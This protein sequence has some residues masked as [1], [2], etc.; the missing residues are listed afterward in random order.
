[1]TNDDS[2]QM[3]LNKI[4]ATIGENIQRYDDRLHELK[5]LSQILFME[6]RADDDLDAWFREEGFGINEDGFWLSLPKLTA[7][8]ENRAAQDIISYSWHPDLISNKDACFRMYALRNIGPL[9]EEIWNSL[10]ETAWIYYQDITNTSLQFPYIDQITAISP[11]FDWR[12]YHTFQSVCPQNNPEGEIKWTQP[13]IDY[14]GEGLI[15]SVSIPVRIQNRFIGLWSIDLP[16]VS[17]YPEFIF[18]TLLE[19]QVNF[20]VDQDGNLVAHP[21]IETRIDSEKGSL[22]QTHFH[23]LGAGFKSLSPRELLK[24]KEGHFV[25]N[26]ETASES[27]GYYHAIPG[28]HWLLFC[29][30]PRQSMEHVIDRKIKTAFERVKSGDFS[31]RLNELS[32]VKHSK[33]IADGFNEM[34]RA[35]EN[36]AEKQKKTQKEKDLLEERI[37]HYQKM[38]AIGTLAGGIAHDFN[39][40]LFPIQGYAEM[41]LDD[42]P[43][44]DPKHEM[45]QEILQAASRAKE[46][47]EQILTF[48]RQGETKNQI[49]SLQSIVKEALK[50]LRSTIPKNIEIRQNVIS[51]CKPVFADPTNLHQVI[52]NLCTNAFHAVQEKGGAIDVALE[53]IRVTTEGQY[54]IVDLPPGNYI[55]LTVSDT[56]CGMDKT[57]LE[58]IFNPYF[59]T[60]KEGKGTGLGLSISYGII[61]TLNGEIKVYSEPNKG[62]TFH[63][64][65]PVT[66]IKEVREPGENINIA[67]GTEHILLVDDE[68]SIAQMGKTALEKYGYRVSVFTSSFEALNAFEKKP[69]SFDLLLTDMTMPDMT[70]DILVQHIKRIRDNIPVIICTGFNENISNVNYADKGADAFLMKPVAIHK[71]IGTIRKQLDK[72]RK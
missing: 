13:T 26:P 64:Y 48:S 59:T 33:I 58:Q 16:M 62:T 46:L 10:P 41:F 21:H 8:R 6:T 71:L 23:E 43:K 65:I 57:T 37:R 28:V 38:E 4:A 27:V 55:R 42:F 47:I 50:L 7:F 20:I 25:L 63:V 32:D 14:A 36:Q 44:D 60:K 9:L 66:S 2:I 51:K 70:G 19:G 69:A 72:I 52:M 30:F 56:G 53:E 31:Y 35:L 54:G 67:K 68:G 17:L 34:A 61:K 45:A 49:V 5:R 40:I 29:V 12:T 22:F 3:Q 11:D 24:K 15:L 1:M 39:N 18:D